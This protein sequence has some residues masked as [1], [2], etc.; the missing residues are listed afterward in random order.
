M[1]SPR[2]RDL[3]AFWFLSV[4]WSGNWLLIKVGLEGLLRF[5]SPACVWFLPLSCSRSS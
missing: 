5:A 2:G 3:A 4:L 1:Q